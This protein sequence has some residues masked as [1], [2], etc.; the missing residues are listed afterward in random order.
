MP[1]QERS[2]DMRMLVIGTAIAAISLTMVST[3]APATAQSAPAKAAYAKAALDFQFY[4]SRVEPIFLK[5]R[6]DHARCYACH[7][8]N[9]SGFHL[10]RL[11]PGHTSWTEEQSRLNFESVSHL[12]V[13]G[14][15][16]ASVLL[17]HPLAPEGGGDA[18]HSGGRQFESKSDTD[19]Q[20]IAEWVRMAK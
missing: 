8:Q 6:G 15:P 20:T 5:Q 17:L 12:V 1:P 16:N 18:F 9:D 3:V 7:S 2:F 14:N 10:Q 4:K 11:L 13:P 19:W